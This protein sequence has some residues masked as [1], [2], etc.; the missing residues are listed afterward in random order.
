ML[1]PVKDRGCR[2][3]Q[4]IGNGQTGNK[5]L[6]RGYQ[7]KS[8]R[9]EGSKAMLM[10]VPSVPPPL[11]KLPAPDGFPEVRY[12]ARV[13]DAL[14]L[15]AAWSYSDYAVLTDAL[16]HRGV[17]DLDATVSQVSIKNEAMLVVSTGF[18]IRSGDLGILCFRGTEPSSAINFLTD[19][20]C[21]PVNFLSMGQVHGG[22][23]RNL[24]AIWQDLAS[25]VEAAI[26]SGMKSLYITGHSLG[27]AMAVLAAA[28][29]YGDSTYAEWKRRFR[30]AYTY[31]QPMVGD[32]EFARSCERMPLFRH[33]YGHDL[34]TRLPPQSTGPFEHFGQEYIGGEDGWRPRSKRRT[35]V[36]SIAL[37]IPVGA[38]A[39]VVKQI[40][41]LGWIR[42]PLSIDDHSPNSYLEAFRAARS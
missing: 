8:I 9:P 33:V 19:A 26:S 30:G 39:F 21:R 32:E 23:Y 3:E 22:F 42:L 17:L 20:S 31:G 34:V 7:P 4:I 2:V 38:A 10:A 13:A 29:I 24:L 36:A 14:S 1:P 18:F 37:S 28:T 16:Q 41:L 40:P 27:A 25:E 11:A 15:V 5:L 35:Q 6:V 12:D